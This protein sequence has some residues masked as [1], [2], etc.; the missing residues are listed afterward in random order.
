MRILEHCLCTPAHTHSVKFLK[1][2][3]SKVL[4][5]AFLSIVHRERITLLSS[6]WP[7]IID[8]WIIIIPLFNASLISSYEVTAETRAA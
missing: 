7:C 8:L 4:C 1:D 2:H 6:Q 5:L 3:L